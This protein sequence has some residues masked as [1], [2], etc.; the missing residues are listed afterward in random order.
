VDT[1]MSSSD[2]RAFWKRFRTSSSKTGRCGE[3]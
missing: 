2:R 1:A 3:N